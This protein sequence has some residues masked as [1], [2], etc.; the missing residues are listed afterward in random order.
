MS[1]KSEKPKLT[2]E[3]IKELT[4]KLFDRLNN[5]PQFQAN[6]NFVDNICK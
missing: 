5:D 4:K 3:L 2:P 6:R 1:D